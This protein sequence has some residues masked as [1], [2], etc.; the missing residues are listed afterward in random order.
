MTW[1]HCCS[2]ENN[3]KE[4]SHKNGKITYETWL[5]MCEYFLEGYYII[6]CKGFYYEGYYITC[7]VL[8][9]YLCKFWRDIT[10]LLFE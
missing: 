4:M 6:A 10:L 9:G 1:S 5:S 8:V 3:L 2:Y 7:T